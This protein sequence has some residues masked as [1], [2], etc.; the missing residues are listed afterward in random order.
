MSEAT[1]TIAGKTYNEADLSDKTK[2]LVSIYRKWNQ[3]LM[4]A[5]LDMSKTE[6][7]LRELSREIVE[8]VQVAVEAP[9]ETTDID[10]S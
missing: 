4:E 2:Q 5:R 8:S 3:D 6:A 9:N 10:A 7:A 1:I